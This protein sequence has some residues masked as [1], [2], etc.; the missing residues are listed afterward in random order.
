MKTSSV[1]EP[2]V[3]NV[4]C[5]TQSVPVILWNLLATYY[6]TQNS[7]YEPELCHYATRVQQGIA[8]S[9][10]VVREKNKKPEAVKFIFIATK[11]K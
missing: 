6:S 9:L 11:L 7:E 4:S 10:L 1:L 3:S 2:T 5:S 8:L